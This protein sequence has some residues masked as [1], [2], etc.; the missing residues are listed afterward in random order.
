MKREIILVPCNKRYYQYEYGNSFSNA[1]FVDINVDNPG[2]VYEQLL[3]YREIIYYTFD[4]DN[5]RLST[6]EEINEFKEFY[7][8]A[9][10]PIKQN[11]P[12]L[13][14][15]SLSN[16]TL[17]INKGYLQNNE[18]TIEDWFENIVG[19]DWRTATFTNPSA[20]NYLLYH[21]RDFDNILDKTTSMILYGKIGGF[22][23]LV[24]V[25]E[26]HLPEN[27]IIEQDYI[28]G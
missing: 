2:K 11:I 6:N 28:I 26:L 24:N 17:K 25:N 19:V 14:T 22:G 16:M 12:K 8:R 27:Y 20:Y 7:S 18:I 9:F 1:L 15:T 5:L 4:N 10:N 13:K 21:Q 3:G 23:Y